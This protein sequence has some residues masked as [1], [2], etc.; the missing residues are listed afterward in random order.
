[1]DYRIELPEVKFEQDLIEEYAGV[2]PDYKNAR[3]TL[4]EQFG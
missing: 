3:K 2:E 1:M 4:Q